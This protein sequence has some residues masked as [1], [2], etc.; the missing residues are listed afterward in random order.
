MAAC[1]GWIVG[2]IL[3]EPF[4]SFLRRQSDIICTVGLNRFFSK[5][6]RHEFLGKASL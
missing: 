2:A 6:M 4:L 5:G 1:R 3:F